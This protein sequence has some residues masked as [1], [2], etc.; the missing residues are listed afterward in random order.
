VSRH[1]VFDNWDWP[2]PLV[3]VFS[4]LL[5]TVLWSA[6][7]LRLSAKRARR[8]ALARVGERISQAKQQG[9]LRRADELERVMNEIKSV[10]DG[11]FSRFRDN[12]IIAAVLIP[13]GGMGA[14]AVIE[15][16][17]RHL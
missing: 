13:S 14:L 10:Q 2:I 5:L 1:P 9:N 7:L 8:T 16:V 6:M 11:A 3:A 12:P 4:F 17:V 15:L